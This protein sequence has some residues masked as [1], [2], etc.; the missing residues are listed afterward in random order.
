MGSGKQPAEAEK[1][2]RAELESLAEKPVP[3]AELEKAKNLILTVRA[4]R[5]RD[6]QRQGVLPRR[7]AH[8]SSTIPAS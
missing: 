7:G 6:E 2:I 8:R 3:A 5:A 1:I 4:A